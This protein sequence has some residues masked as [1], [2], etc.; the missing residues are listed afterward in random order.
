MT[1]Q[2][3]EPSLRGYVRLAAHGFALPCFGQGDRPN[4]WYVARSSPEGD[5]LGSIAALE[6]FAHDEIE[7]LPADLV[8][9]IRLGEPWVDVFLWR[10]LPL[11]GTPLEIWNAI[12]ANAGE[13][14]DEA[15]LSLL[16]LAM[17]VEAPDWPLLAKGCFDFLESRFGRASAGAWRRDIYFRRNALLAVRRRLPETSPEAV[18][19]LDVQEVGDRLELSDPEQAVPRLAEVAAL[20]ESDLQ[21]LASPFGFDVEPIRATSLSSTPL[22]AAPPPAPA[23]LSDILVVAV[24]TRAR[25]I[26]RHFRNPDWT[27]A[28]GGSQGYRIREVTD[29][30]IENSD[31]EPEIVIAVDRVPSLRR[32]FGA[33]V[34]LADDDI[35]ADLLRPAASLRIAGLE[36]ARIRL[37]APALPVDGPSEVLTRPSVVK[38][39]FHAMVDTSIARSP[40]WSGNPWRALDRRIADTVLGAAQ[41]A[42]SLEAVADALTS[43]ALQERE[44]P[45]LTF[46]LDAGEQP[47]SGMISEATGLPSGDDGDP[48]IIRTGFHPRWRGERPKWAGEG[49]AELRRSG[50]RDVA[51]FLY[52]AALRAA[53]IAV[54]AEPPRIEG[55]PEGLKSRLR[56]PDLAASF[57]AGAEAKVP[58]TVIAEVPDL[59]AVRAANSAG[60]KVARYTDAEFIGELLSGANEH[61]LPS[62][63]RLPPLDRRN[64]NRGLATRGVDPRDVIELDVK[65]AE[66]VRRGAAPLAPEIRRFRAAFQQDQGAEER[67]LLPT[68]K[69]GQWS[70]VVSQDKKPAKPGREVQALLQGKPRSPKRPADL[71]VAWSSPA[72][73]SMRFI[74]ADGPIPLLID[75]LEPDCVPAQSLFIVDGDAAVPALFS[76]RIFQVW[77]RATTTRSTSWMS[78]FSVTRTF[79]TFPV[80]DAFDIVHPRAGTPNLH[81]REVGP[82]SM[83][84][85]D[86]WASISSRRGHLRP[87]TEASSVSLQLDGRL[88]AD[89]LEVYGLKASAD[90][91]AILER[92]I[93]LNHVV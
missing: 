37:L 38:G 56:F 52:A 22:T 34:V 65:L 29:G 28:G 70:K 24:G 80:A 18:R 23:R 84:A 74:L 20:L 13:I 21:R 40:F 3:Q 67:F 46:A 73:G 63:L 58:L 9:A 7:L 76:S 51:G 89:F 32:E 10:G 90:D 14:A 92:L 41:I 15:P 55:A 48:A 68:A 81:F 43:V 6:V 88:E 1:L 11:V 49:V 82:I 60:W 25:E 69:A 47:E 66:G 62:E 16:D 33:V 19:R 53:K 30:D 79:E 45:F 44:P 2:A 85:E 87:G 35:A 12:S 54:E 77:A 8:R 78:R 39:P 64:S 59:E 42:A 57:S 31:G 36:R 4:T 61:R 17:D 50:D 71:A 5:H 26:A 93:E 75:Q 72:Q 27:I 83:A 91:A 86:W